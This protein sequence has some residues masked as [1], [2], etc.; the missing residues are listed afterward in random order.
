ML[1]LTRY[2]SPFVNVFLTWVKKPEH[3]SKLHEVYC[4]LLN[5]SISD[6]SLTYWPWSSWPNS[7]SSHDFVI[8]FLPKYNGFVNGTKTAF[9]SAS[10]FN[11]S[12]FHGLF[13]DLIGGKILRWKYNTN[14]DNNE[15]KWLSWVVKMPF[16]KT[17]THL[18]NPWVHLIGQNDARECVLNIPNKCWMGISLLEWSRW[19][20]IQAVYKKRILWLC[21]TLDW[22]PL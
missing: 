12:F 9:S 6:I 5:K 2:M 19:H 20:E 3:A 18:I 21:D 15:S 22:K 1:L 14:N 7:W 10:V 17:R 4:D 16:R 13:W 8:V 11:L